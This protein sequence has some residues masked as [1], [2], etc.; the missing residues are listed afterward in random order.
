[1]L[2][3]IERV[4]VGDARRRSEGYVAQRRGGQ[5]SSALAA[6]ETIW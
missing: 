2:E 5:A 1:V 4:R 3:A 6:N